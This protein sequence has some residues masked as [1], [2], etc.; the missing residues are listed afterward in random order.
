MD[1]THLLTSFDGRINRKAFWIAFAVVFAAEVICHLLA[2]RIEGDRLSAI[3][4][5]AFSYPE[6]AI[7]AK[8]GH[9]RNVT[10]WVPGVIFLASVILDFLVVL[11]FGGPEGA[12]STVRLIVGVPLGLLSLA[13][14][15]DFGFRKGTPGPNRY[16]PEPIND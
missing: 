14:L 10:T 4:D 9:D 12:P 2:Q 5:L 15:I 7:F 16:G 6:F 3:V 1:W 11:G 8:R 13:L